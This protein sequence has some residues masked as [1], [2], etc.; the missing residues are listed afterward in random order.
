MVTLLSELIK[1]ASIPYHQITGRLK[2]RHSLEKKISGQQDKYTRLNDITDISGIRIIT[3]LESNV[4]AVAKIIEGEFEIDK[5]NSIDK[6]QLKEDQFGYRSLHYVVECNKDRLKLSEYQRFSG[7][8]FEIQVRSILQ[9]AWAEIEHDLGYKG[10]VSIP[11]NYKRG[12]N[13]VAALLETAD[14]EFDRL[15]RDLTKYETQIDNLIRTEP[16]NVLLDQ[17][18]LL[19]FN[20]K[21]SILKK[22]RSII[23]KNTGCAFVYN[24]KFDDYL[25]RFKSLFDVVTIDKLSSLL[26]QYEKEFLVFVNLFTVPFSQDHLV[27][28]IGLFYF[29][30][31]L[32]AVNEDQGFVN[33]YIEISN[34]SSER[35]KFIELVRQAKNEVNKTNNR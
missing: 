11:V 33:K 32:S 8:K 18:S 22:A 3:Y 17:V 6:R 15:K 12:F 4:D 13:R 20:Q 1:N 29:Q 35:G 27:E 28:S 26:N 14:I 2:E 21:N 9:H 25:D 5:H 19:S 31:F 10:S 30:H 24:T 16:Q 23:K 7:K 34:M